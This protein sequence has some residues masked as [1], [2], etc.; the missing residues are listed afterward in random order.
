MK[1]LLICLLSI[2]LIG[3]LL[4]GCGKTINT[5]QA[6]NLKQE[7]VAKESAKSVLFLGNSFTY[8]NELPEIFKLLASAGGYNVSVDS[9]TKGGGKLLEF[10][11]ELAGEVSDKFKNKWDIVV[12]QE[13]SKIPTIPKDRKESMYPSVRELNKKITENGAKAMMY[14]TWGYRYGDKDNGYA[15]F[16]DMQEALKVGYM[17]IAQELSLPVAPVGLAFLKAK[18]KDKNI[19]LWDDDNLHPNIKGSYLAGCV[20]YAEIFQKSPVG[21]N[22]VSHLSSEDAKFLQQIAE[23]TVLNNK[24]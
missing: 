17:D 6:D 21:L 4:T 19:N 20:F 15:T 23:E 18:Q 13:Q 14:M 9:V 2:C 7:S 5:K 10:N 8:Y 3:N 1:R 24:K 12:L 22:Y 16:E 11:N